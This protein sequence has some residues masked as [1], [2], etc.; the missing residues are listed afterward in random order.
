VQSTS[1]LMR[2]VPYIK[3]VI[4]DADKIHV[5]EPFFAAHMKIDASLLADINLP[6]T[7]QQVLLPLASLRRR[8]DVRTNDA[9]WIRSESSKVKTKVESNIEV[10]GRLGLFGDQNAGNSK[11]LDRVIVEGKIND[12]LPTLSK[13]LGKGIY[14]MK[15]RD[16]SD[17][18]ESVRE[19]AHDINAAINFYQK[20][21]GVKAE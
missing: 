14:D 11:D 13:I 1:T 17:V 15:R 16:K 10:L 2:T 18:S 12:L 7:E 8:Q 21:F 20:I 5:P 9:V 6:P 3:G 19:S 4:P